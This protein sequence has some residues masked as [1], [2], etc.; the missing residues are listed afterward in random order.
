MI[1]DFLLQLW[2]LI[3]GQVAPDYIIKA[4]NWFGFALFIIFIFLPIIVMFT[5]FALFRKAGRYD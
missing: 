5:V 1:V 3:G 4:I 2:Y